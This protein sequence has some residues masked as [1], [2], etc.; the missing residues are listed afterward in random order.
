M[1]QLKFITIIIREADDAVVGLAI[2]LPSLSHAL[3][4]A[5]GKF[6]PFGFIYLLK[7][8]YLKPKVIDFYL[9][10]VLP[11]YQSK[12]VNSLV[13]NDLLP[14]YIKSGAVYAESNPE[15]ETNYAVQAQWQYFKTEYHKRRRAYIK[16]I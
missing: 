16:E 3:Q 4:K 1:L 10:G 7:A 14:E 15:L 13:F 5:K 2:T 9:L 8:L 6:F 12:G 11:E